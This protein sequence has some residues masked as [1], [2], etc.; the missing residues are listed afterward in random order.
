MVVYAVS[1]LNY[2]QLRGQDNCS[3][4]TINFSYVKQIEQSQ[5]CEAIWKFVQ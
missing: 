4:D 5:E 2:F 1:P 3:I